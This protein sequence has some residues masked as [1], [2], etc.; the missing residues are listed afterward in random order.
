MPG[1]MDTVLNLGLKDETVKGLIGKTD[2][3]R[4]GR[5][6]FSSGEG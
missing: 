1:M 5:V 4:F 6:V 2:N 3:P